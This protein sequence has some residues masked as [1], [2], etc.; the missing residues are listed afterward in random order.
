MAYFNIQYENMKALSLEV[1]EKM[2]FTADESA[3][4]TDVFILR[5][6]KFTNVPLS[7][8]SG[9]SV[10]T[11][12]NYYIYADDVDSDGTLEL[13][14][15]IDMQPVHNNPQT[16][17]QHLIRWYALTEDGDAVDKLHTFHNFDAGWY[18]SLSGDWA[19]RV[20]VVQSAGVCT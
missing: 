14:C 9:T 11:L 1:F 2:G 20:S 12:R 7:A 18:L 17:T 5:N 16:A 15:L 4:I 3:I 6:G 19:G 8:E 13:P 10:A